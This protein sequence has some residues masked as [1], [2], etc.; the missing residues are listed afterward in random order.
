[1]AV[2]AAAEFSK[3]NG[4]DESTPDA[5]SAIVTRT[6]IATKRADLQI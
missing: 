4:C 3:G 6:I 2:R 1:V 5:G